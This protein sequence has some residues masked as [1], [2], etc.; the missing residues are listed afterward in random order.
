MCALARETGSASFLLAAGNLSTS[1]RKRFRIFVLARS[2]GLF[3]PVSHTVISANFSASFS[4][5]FSRYFF[6]SG[7]QL[8][9]IGSSLLST[10]RFA[11]SSD[12]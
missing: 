5:S 6:A 12:G 4:L 1:S 8:F 9:I 11:R 3:A 2:A 10:V 7:A